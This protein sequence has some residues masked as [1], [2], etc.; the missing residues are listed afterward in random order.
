MS[1]ELF[2]YWAARAET[3]RGSDLW[4][5]VVRL[6][7]RQHLSE[8]GRTNPDHEPTRPASSAR[9][10]SDPVTRGESIILIRSGSQGPE[11]SQNLPKGALGGKAGHV[12]QPRHQ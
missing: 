10:W 2:I 11:I 4:A 6:A 7:I 12:C 8:R 9:A 3:D 5:L 1:R